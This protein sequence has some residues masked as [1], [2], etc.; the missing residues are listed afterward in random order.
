VN[1]IVAVVFPGPRAFALELIVKVT[2][3][4]EVPTVP[5]VDDGVSQLGTPDIE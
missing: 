4:G 1:E 2:V 5:D 3:V